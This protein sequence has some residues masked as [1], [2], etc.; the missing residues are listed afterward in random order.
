[1]TSSRKPPV[2]AW[3]PYGA[4]LLAAYQGR[5][6]PSTATDDELVKNG[7]GYALQITCLASAVGNNGLGRHADAFAAARKTAYEVSFLAPFAL[8]ELIEAAA[9]TGD[10]EA[11]GDALEQ[12]VPPCPQ[13]SSDWAAG[14]AARGRALLDGDD[15]AARWHRESIDRLTRTPLRP[16]LGRAHDLYGEWLRRADRRADAR[17]Q[18]RVA[19]QLFIEMGAEAFAE[20][21]R[22]EAAAAGSEI[23]R[24]T[25]TR[26]TPEPAGGTHRA[27]GAGRAHQFRDRRAAVH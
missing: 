10:H 14:M 21:A 19:C 9:K 1:M 8:S 12:L 15:G 23:G 7:D 27:A 3:R 25:S 20:R 6:A 11:A 4:Q 18:L 5:P 22:R 2:F 26:R 17:H 16:E 24:G 13:P